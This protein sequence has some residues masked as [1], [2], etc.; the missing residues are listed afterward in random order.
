M[1]SL[2]CPGSKAM[3]RR[4]QG[5][6]TPSLQPIQVSSVHVYEIIHW[7]MPDF[8]RHVSILPWSQLLGW[9]LHPPC[10][11]LRHGRHMREVYLYG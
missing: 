7:I 8:F 1:K 4:Y 6:G 3:F 2:K 9:V 11:F 10:M 5:T